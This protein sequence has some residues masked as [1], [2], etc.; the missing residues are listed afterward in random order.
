MQASSLQKYLRISPKK[1]RELARLTV[2]LTPDIAANKLELMGGKASKLLSAVIKSAKSNAVNNLK[3]SPDNLII[4]EVMTLK[5]PFLKR[6]QPV[7]RG[8]AHQ[9]K[10]RT[11]HLKVTVAEKVIKPKEIKK[12]ASVK[13]DPVN[14][15]K[16][17]IK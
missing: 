6:W 5:G 12:E 15:Q 8:T 1:I 14:V 10:K 13:L 4:K 7:A 9:L 11:A 3:L 16:E 17:A 2:G